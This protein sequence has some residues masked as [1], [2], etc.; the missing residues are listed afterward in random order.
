MEKVRH[1]LNLGVDLLKK[2]NIPSPHLDAKVLLLNALKKETTST[3][4]ITKENDIVKEE[5]LKKY[6][7][8]IEKRCDKIPLAYIIG[9]KEF[10]NLEFLVNHNTLIPRPDTEIL[11]SYLIDKYKDKKVKILEIGIGSG[12]I[13]ISLGKYI[14]DSKIIGVDIS[15]EANEVASKNLKKHNLEGKISFYKSD[16]FSSIEEKSFDIIVSNPPYIEKDTIKTLIEEVKDNEPI[17]ALDG[18]VS[19]LDFYEKIT[20]E[21]ISYIKENG[22]LIFEIGYNQGVEVSNILK[23]NNYSNIEII[24]DYSG[25]DRVVLGNYNP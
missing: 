21:S 1:L 6:L 9:K 22:L 17:L 15:Q 19:G 10:M 4:L 8:M 5:T 11:V 13:S 12:C 25:N 14:K 20:K 18:G 24:K 16:L 23:N 3:Y 2:N 7:S